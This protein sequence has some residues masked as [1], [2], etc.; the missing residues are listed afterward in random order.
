MQNGVNIK[1][2]EDD[3]VVRKLNKVASKLSK[4]YSKKRKI[5]T[6]LL[7]KRPLPLRIFSWVINTLAVLVFVFGIVF[8]CSATYNKI[9]KIP[10]SF[11]GYVSTQVVSKSMENSGFH[12][13][14]NVIVRAV[15]THTLK[16]GDIIAFYA[17]SKYPKK[18][19]EIEPD[20]LGKQHLTY[21]IS[22]LRFFG[23][24]PTEIENAAKENCKLVFHHIKRIYEDE[25]GNRYFTTY[26][27]S[28]INELTNQPIEDGWLIS[29]KL[30][31]G[32]YDNS[33]MAKVS[34]LVIKGVSSPTGM[35]VLL[36]IPVVI[37]MYSLILTALTNVQLAFLENDVVEEKRKLT[38]PICV[39]NEI[40]YKMSKITKYKV[41]AQASDDEKLEYIN[42]LWKTDKRPENIRKHYLKK[43][44][45]LRPMQKLRDVNRNCEQM[46]KDGVEPTK[47]AKYYTEEKEKI[48]AEQKRYKALVKKIGENN[49]KRAQLDV[50]AQSALPAQAKNKTAKPKTQPTPETKN[51]KT[52]K[53]KTANKMAKQVKN[54]TK[55]KKCN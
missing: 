1:V 44:L 31:V 17:S 53:T 19:K 45:I 5:N 37:I 20:Q 55:N 40:G 25:F 24:M 42:L 3:S 10:P 2:V 34:A 43:D 28:N 9:N 8:C 23:V 41:L 36:L 7:K 54:A 13:G 47:I 26:G 50:N 51:K 18:Y 27:S 4:K 46:F 22:F 16:P 15:D 48:Q 38:D 30:I 14:D 33:A 29:E 32:C 39:A 35:F 21:K 49:K 12:K 11:A 6:R 52:T